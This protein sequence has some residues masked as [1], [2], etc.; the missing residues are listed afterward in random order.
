MN[1]ENKKSLPELLAPA[2]SLR[3]LEAAIDAGAD[4]VYFGATGFNARINA[5]NFSESSMSEALGLCR[6]YGVKSYVTLNTLAL[7]RELSEYVKTAEDV[8]GKG[9][10]AL[11]VADIGGAAVLKRMYPEIELHA[12]TQLSGHNTA[13]ARLLSD[14]G[15]SRMVL[16]RETS[17]DNIKYFTANSPIEAEIFVHGALCVSHSGQCLFSSLV[18]GRSGNRGECAQPCR[19]PFEGREKYPLSLKDFCLAPYI[20]EIID[21]GVASLKIEG[22][23]KSPEYVHEVVSVYRRLLDERRGADSAEIKYLSSVFSRGGFTD[24]YFTGNIGH[25]ML[26]IRSESDKG[27]S[28][29]LVPFDRIKKKLPLTLTACFKA[30]EAS[31]LTLSCGEKTVTVTGD[32]PFEAI[33]APMTEA[34]VLS[35]LSKLGDTPYAI[36]KS[37]INIEGRIMLPVSKLNA[38]RRSAVEAL[39]GFSKREFERKAYSLPKIAK[40]DEETALCSAVFREEKQITNLASGFFDKIYLPLDRYTERANGVILP[41]VVFDSDMGKVGEMLAEAVK[42]GAKYALCTNLGQLEMI[43]KSGLIPEAD[44]RLNIFNRE[45]AS[46]LK[47]LG[48]ESFIASPELTL[49]QIRDLGNGKAVTVYGRLPLMLLEKCVIKEI[50][51]CD[52]CR[53]DKAVLCDRRGIR[54]PVMREWEHRNVIYNSLPTYMGDRKDILQKYGI[55]NIHFIFSFESANEV[56]RVIKAYR[57]G[58]SL[59]DVRR[60]RE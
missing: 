19:L 10:D 59:P 43:K 52:V 7:D 11:I 45:S 22:R 60:I 4:A 29:T 35:S 34:S 56:D 31:R 44:L 47:R 24:G 8:L 17:L 48:F 6:M 41:P 27:S 3:A 39:M 15:F 36:E 18:G 20:P 5:E 38:L 2:G 42:K 33:N 55:K 14:M 9:A 21:S 1:R 58:A 25:R 13:E 54:F 12:S 46:G 50:A 40:N 16:A 28:R 26:G 32:V 23:M 57:E 30:G 37:S 53:K 51:D 49:P